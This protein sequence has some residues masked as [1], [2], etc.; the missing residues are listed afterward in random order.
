MTVS[1]INVPDMHCSAC[2]GKIRSA[3]QTLAGVDATYFNPAR[4]QVLI[5]H[6]DQLGSLELLKSI[7]AAGFTPSLSGV[8]AHDQRQKALLKRLGIAGL[9]MMQVMMAAIAMY[10]GDFQQMEESYRRLLEFTS[11]IFCIPVIAYSAMPFFTGALAAFRTGINMDVP[12]ALAI[13]IAF[14]ISVSNTLS[15]NGDVYYDSVVMFTFLLLGARYI[16]SRLQQR[17][18]TTDKALAALPTRALRINGARQDLVAVPDIQV[19]DRLWISEGAQ[20]PVDGRLAGRAADIDEAVLSG[21][22]DWVKK[23]AQAPL[24]AGTINC[25]PGFEMIVSAGYEASRIADIAALA[26]RAQ[27]ERAPA[28]LLADRIAGYFIP[29]VLMLATLTYIGWQIFDPDRAIV[30]ALTVLVVS[31]P[32]ALSLATPAALTAAMTRLR[33]LGIVLTRSSALE[34]AAKIDLAL[35]DKTGTLTV[36]EPTVTD[37]TLL[38]A[39]FD[40]ATCHALAGALQQYSAHPYARAFSHD[41]SIALDEVEV[42]TG[43]GV[44]GIWAGHRVV[45]G[46]ASFCA[47]GSDADRAVYLAV[48]GVARARFTISDQVRGDAR[49]AM[50][51]LAELGIKP[52]MLS[53][54]AP[55]RCEELATKLG[56]N[57]L[58]RQTPESKLAFLEA[59]LR[60]GHRT[61]MLGDGIN[62]VPVLA[63]A[64]VSAAVVEASDLVKSKADVLL[65]SRRLNPLPELIRVA[66]KTQHITRQNLTWALAYN[67]IAIPIAAMGWM[68][69]WLAALGMA[70]S[71]TLVMFN[72]TR[73]LR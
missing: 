8:E 70:S 1:T 62:D 46:S 73:I 61:L 23:T 16:D 7:E 52:M 67:L 53:G 55:A 41:A 6:Q 51:D 26:D 30:A 2:S 72:A 12:I 13:S 29:T 22:A 69:P 27:L 49:Q 3:L 44:R 36:H 17:F 32:C 65:L 38:N 56:I 4:R 20:I 48:D 39:E 45:I 19:G 14:T 42:V 35:I 63:A 5:E 66:R 40:E 11:L 43:K 58:A 21:E 15:G 34:Q 60:D 31:C 28:A 68:P 18:A 54:D 33:D 24:W 47:T 10:A 64:T 25:G 57:Y 71:S 59:Q 50:D 9:A 37:T